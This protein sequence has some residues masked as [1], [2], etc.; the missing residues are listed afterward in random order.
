[1]AVWAAMALSN[2]PNAAAQTFCAV[3]TPAP[4]DKLTNL[5]KKYDGTDCSITDVSVPD[6]AYV[7]TS[8]SENYKLHA[9][10]STSGVCRQWYPYPS[11]SSY[12]FDDGRYLGYSDLKINGGHY[13][14]L[15]TNIGNLSYDARQL[16]PR[17]SLVI[18]G[19]KNGLRHAGRVEGIAM[20]DGGYLDLRRRP[21]FKFARGRLVCLIEDSRLEVCL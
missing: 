20:A 6:R 21:D 7:K 16:R 1:M 18:R 8:A 4:T 9:I 11:C 14:Y 17:R 13:G 5:V 2:A 3:P 12:S 10:A 19:P 15:T